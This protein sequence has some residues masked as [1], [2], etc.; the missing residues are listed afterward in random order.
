MTSLHTHVRALRW[1]GYYKLAKSAACLLALA[2]ALRLTRAERL[3]AA[4]AWLERLRADPHNRM[5][6]WLVSYVPDLTHERVRLLVIALSVYAVLYA[7]QGIGLIAD[8]RWAEY[9]TVATTSLL[10]PVEFYEVLHAPTLMKGLVLAVNIFVVA[11]L[12]RDLRRPP[13][14][15]A[16]SARPLP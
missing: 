4:L 15:V 16:P 14:D 8:R 13:T 2:G 11:F 7:I 12:S 9:L 3:A 5:V 10:L 6:E 1:I